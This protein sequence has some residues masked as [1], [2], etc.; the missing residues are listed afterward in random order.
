[1]KKIGI[2][3]DNT[4]AD[5]I[6][7][8]TPLM[9]EHYGLEPVLDRPAYSIEEVFGITP[10]TRPANMRQL[11]YVERNLFAKLPKLEEDNHR[12][13][14]QLRNHLDPVKIYFVTARDPHPTI[15][16]DTREWLEKN[17]GTYDDVFHVGKKAD[18]CKYAGISVM[19]EDEIRQII[20][21]IEAGV[22]VIVMDQPWNRHLPADPHGI[23]DP[24]GRIQ[25]VSD[26][27][28]ALIA[29]KEFLS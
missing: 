20:P 10:E 2:D 21:L 29:A 26:W 22:D 27:R 6:A 4:V 23:E 12:L 28:E 7:G 5:F 8:V 18:F 14:T 24:K 15:L 16:R 9:K 25:R 17:T 3:L 19:I 13:T 11:L 1:M